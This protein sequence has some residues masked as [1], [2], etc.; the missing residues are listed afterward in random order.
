MAIIIGDTDRTIDLIRTM[1]GVML[2]FTTHFIMV[3]GI[4]LITTTG[5]MDILI[6]DIVMV[7]T[8]ILIIIIT[9][10]MEFITEE[11]THTTV[12]DAGVH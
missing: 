4:V 3:L 5:I 12:V 1:D 6:M 11:I 9:I 8:V 2:V 7:I 10:I